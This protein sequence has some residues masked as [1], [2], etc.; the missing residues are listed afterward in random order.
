M[1]TLLEYINEAK[2]LITPNI[3]IDEFIDVLKERGYTFNKE[4]ARVHIS[5]DQE[6][7]RIMK[8]SKDSFFDFQDKL[9]DTKDY[10]WMYVHPNKSKYIYLIC[11]DKN[12]KFLHGTEYG[13]F[14]TVSGFYTVDLFDDLMMDMGLV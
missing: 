13:R 5:D 2:S 6:A 7:Y 1:K 11:F 10:R 12:G 4:A 9:L 14:L 8:Q 3:T